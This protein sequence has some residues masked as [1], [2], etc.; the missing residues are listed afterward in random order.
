MQ[1]GDQRQDGALARARRPDDRRGGARLKEKLTPVEDRGAGA[2]VTEGDVV[3]LDARAPRR[4]PR[5]RAV[6]AATSGA[7]S[8]DW[9]RSSVARMVS[10]AGAN[11]LRMVNG[12]R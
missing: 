8:T 11:S 10:S 5:R 12:S 3:E 2:V 4:R 9:M 7:V 1:S 6:P